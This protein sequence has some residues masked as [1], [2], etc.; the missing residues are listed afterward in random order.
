MK[1]HILLLA[2][3]V[4]TFSFCQEKLMTRTGEVT[5]SSETPME[6]IYAKNSQ[7]ASILLPDD[8]TIAFN[9]LMKSFKFEK[10][11]MEEH[12]NEKYVHS[13]QYPAA[14]FKGTI[15]SN[16]DLKT[17]KKYKNVPIKG[18]MIFHGVTKPLEVYADITVKNDGSVA[19]TSEFMLALKDYKIE[20]PSLVKDK[21]SEEIQVK[22][23]TNYNK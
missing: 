12:F 8:K 2:L 11:L 15:P 19:F 6:N 3:L 14:K 1:N 10:A 21:I 16:I 5:F 20:V 22:V 13:D 23:A 18:K 7:T 4:S 17:P 9:I